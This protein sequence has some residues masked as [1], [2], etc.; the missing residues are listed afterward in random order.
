[1]ASYRKEYQTNKYDPERAKKLLEEAGYGDGELSFYTVV[2]AN[3]V[4]SVTLA[5]TVQDFL[6]DVGVNLEIDTFDFPTAL[7]LQRNGTVDLCI[8][9]FYTSNCDISG[10]LVQLPEGSYNQAAWLTQL[11]QSGGQFEQC[12]YAATEEGSRGGVQLG[13]RDWLG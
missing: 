8:T 13:A 7:K 5:E 2:S 3:D 6:S 10:C 1:M 4:S 11:D 12:L 9:T